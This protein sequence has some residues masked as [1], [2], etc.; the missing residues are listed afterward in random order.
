[1]TAAPE[2]TSIKR[3]VLLMDDAERRK[4]LAEHPE[5]ALVSETLPLRA[6]LSVSE[7][8]TMVL[9]YRTNN[10]I[11]EADEKAWELIRLLK[12]EA[13]AD[14]RDP[15]LSHEERF[16]AKLLRAVVVRPALI[17]IDRPALL[18]PDTR[19]PQFLNEILR[20]LEGRF[21]QCWI[22]DYA[23]NKPLYE[24]RG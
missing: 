13:C 12:C 17:L 6:N 16:I 21:E 22:L 15:D 1:M 7:N 24:N 14:K 23:W 19:Y 9:Q 8:I 20:V 5:A 10:F 11:G 3:V 4:R 18:L 2:N